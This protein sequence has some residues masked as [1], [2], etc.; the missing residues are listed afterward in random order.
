MQFLIQND[1]TCFVSLEHAAASIVSLLPSPLTA[2]QSNV[3]PER[4]SRSMSANAERPVFK[5]AFRNSGAT[6]GQIS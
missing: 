1:A 3:L 4:I 5:T 6:A 2:S